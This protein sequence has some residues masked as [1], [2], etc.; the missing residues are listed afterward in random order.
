M[1]I[2]DFIKCIKLTP[3]NAEE[4]ISKIRHDIF[5][6]YGGEIDYDCRPSGVTI[7]GFSKNPA[8]E[9]T[10]TWD[11]VLEYVMCPQV[12]LW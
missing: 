3:D 5:G 12:R 8:K 7:N 2:E 10:M 6:S 11:E 4:R 1:T 9:I